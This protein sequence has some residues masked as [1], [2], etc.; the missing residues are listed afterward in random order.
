MTK[1]RL[2]PTLSAPRVV[3]AL[4]GACVVL[5][6]GSVGSAA[7]ADSHTALNAPPADAK[8]SDASQNRLASTPLETAAERL[9]KVSAAQVL[10]L[11][12]KQIGVHEN[13]QGGGT[14]FHSW[15]MS[16]PRAQE[17][18]ARDG[19]TLRGY[20]NA[21]WCA[22]FV[23][24]VGEMAGIRPT[25]G[26][27]AY[28]VTHAKW[29][30]ENKHWGTTP[31]PGAVVYFDWAGSKSI[32]GIDHVGFVKKDNGDG[33]ITTIEGNTGNGNVEQR[34]RPVSQVVGY[35]YPVYSN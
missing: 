33:T 19:G 31:T 34:I 11:A 7:L 16:S 21:P 28:T 26:W 18:V 24:W 6:T 27:D 12:S 20:A 9:P 14:K 17:T 23:S 1:N 22:M 29:F 4:L 30:K 5:A 25:M 8:V 32:D 15:Y 2:T 35:G 13:A 10:D 3:S